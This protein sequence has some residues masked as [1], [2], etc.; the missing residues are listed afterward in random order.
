VLKNYSPKTSCSLL[1]LPM[2]PSFAAVFDATPSVKDLN[3]AWYAQMPKAD[4]DATFGFQGAGGGS[5]GCSGDAGRPRGS[6]FHGW[7][8]WHGSQN[9]EMPA[10]R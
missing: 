7:A 2:W 6:S 1:A 4:A 9:A 3:A 5:E 10:T 8:Y